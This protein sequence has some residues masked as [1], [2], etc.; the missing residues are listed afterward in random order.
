MPVFGQ[1]A[2]GR[3][4]GE[5]PTGTVRIDGVAAGRFRPEW[6]QAGTLNFNFDARAPML[7]P[8]TG[9]FRSIYAPSVVREDGRWRLS[10]VNGPRH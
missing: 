10:G 6:W 3:T 9:A 4:D 8:R 5:A 7:E 1:P 2:M